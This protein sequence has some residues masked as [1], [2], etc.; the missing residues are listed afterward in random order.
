MCQC[1]SE[2]SYMLLN[3]QRKARAR[4]AQLYQQ[5]V[6]EEKIW[7]SCTL[8]LSNILASVFCTNMSTLAVSVGSAN[9]CKYVS[10]SSSRKN[11]LYKNNSWLI[12]V[13]NMYKQGIIWTRYNMYKLIYCWLNIHRSI[14]HHTDLSFNLGTC[15]LKKYNQVMIQWLAI[16]IIQGTTGPI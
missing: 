15:L 6:F 7:T 16:C 8:I 13:T 5:G 12:R 14:P 3:H 2:C 1:D 10:I 4:S 11:Q 9:P